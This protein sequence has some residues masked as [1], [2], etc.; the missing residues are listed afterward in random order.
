MKVTIKFMP[1]IYKDTALNNASQC[2]GC[3]DCL[4]CGNTEEEL[5]EN[6]REKI[7]AMSSE[8]DILDE[9]IAKRYNQWIA[10]QWKSKVPK[11]ID[12]VGQ[13]DMRLA[14]PYSA[15]FKQWLRENN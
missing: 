5:F 2:I 13:R 8:A 11:V 15:K 3:T 14:L 7:W 1:V 6:I 12:T 9:G 10:D 4:V